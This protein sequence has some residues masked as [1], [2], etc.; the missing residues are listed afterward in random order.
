MKQR[1]GRL[2][3]IK[4]GRRGRGKLLKSL[5]NLNLILILLVKQKT[6]K[7]KKIKCRSSSIF[8]TINKKFQQFL[9]Q[10]PFGVFYDIH[11]I[12]IQC[13]LL[14]HLMILEYE[15]VRDDMFV[16]KINGIELRFGIKEFAAITGLKCGLLT[17]FFSDYVNS[18]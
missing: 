12:R 8:K 4:R 7:T 16:V 11:H 10:T 6:K 17:D 2:R 5:L 9:E 13:Q 3:Q 15:N 14:R 1:K 18:Q